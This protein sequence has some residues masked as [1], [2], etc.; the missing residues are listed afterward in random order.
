M[1]GVQLLNAAT[2][3]AMIYSEKECLECTQVKMNN[4]FDNWKDVMKGYYRSTYKG[5]IKSPWHHYKTKKC[6]SKTKTFFQKTSFFQK[7]L[8][9]RK[10]FQKKCFQ[11]RVSQKS[12]S[13]KVFPKTKNAKDEK[14]SA[15]CPF[16]AFGQQKTNESSF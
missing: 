11:K 8:P 10:R 9:T 7:V 6:F 3:K 4:L 2:E 16:F 1:P 13:K 14:G 5:L 12:V 15:K